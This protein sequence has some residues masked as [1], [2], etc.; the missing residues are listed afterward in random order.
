MARMPPLLVVEGS[1]AAA[2]ERV[3]AALAAAR[4]DGWS[5]VRGWAAPL[6]RDRVVCTGSVRT[7]D[8]ARRALLAAV[9][10]AGLAVA[11]SAD[12]DTIDRFLDDLRRLG[13]VEHVTIRSSAPVSLTPQQRALLGLVA[14][15]LTIREAAVELGLARTTAQRRIDAARAVLPAG[16]AGAIAA[17][18]GS[19]R[20]RSSTG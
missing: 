2:T 7:T 9:S 5:I 20:E 3:A 8:D 12:R 18:L 13:P 6:R 17:A 10:G 19:R 4:D 11:A 16:P 15:G 1:R 14:E